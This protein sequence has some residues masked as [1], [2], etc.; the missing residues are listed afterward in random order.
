VR[1][2]LGQLIRSATGLVAKSLPFPLD[3][4]AHAFTAAEEVRGRDWIVSTTSIPGAARKWGFGA[5]RVYG[6]GKRIVAIAGA[7]GADILIEKLLQDDRAAE[8]E[9]TAIYLLRCRRSQT[10]VE[11]GPEVTVG[12]RRRRPD[13]SDSRQ[14]KSLDL[15]GG[16]AAQ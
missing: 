16:D 10:Q 3:D 2:W 14:K 9:L 15:C 4:L 7:R 5:H 11:V 12:D 6:F 13:F 8:S 1:S